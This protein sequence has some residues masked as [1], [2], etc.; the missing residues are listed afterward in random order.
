MNKK[1]SHIES[2]RFFLFKT[3][4]TRVLPNPPGLDSPR[5]NFVSH[6]RQTTGLCRTTPTS[7]TLK[8]KGD[9]TTCTSDSNRKL[10]SVHQLSPIEKVT[11]FFL[12]KVG[13]KIIDFNWRGL[14]FCWCFNLH[15]GQTHRCLRWEA[16]K[17]WVGFLSKE[18]IR[19]F[20]RRHYAERNFEWKIGKKK[21]YLRNCCWEKWQKKNKLTLWRYP[22][23]SKSFP[24]FSSLLPTTVPAMEKR[25]NSRKP[26]GPRQTQTL[27]N[28]PLINCW[29]WESGV[30]SKGMW[31]IFGETSVFCCIVCHNSWKRRVSCSEEM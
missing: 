2:T 28:S 5:S 10:P 11:M 6:L 4:R 30:C 29:E 24:N 23:D 9:R 25:K 17:W 14:F 16:K 1:W 15:L 18:R 26:V 22:F 13:K 31:N 3:L 21:Q 20:K 12:R 7:K 19:N 8:A 27:R